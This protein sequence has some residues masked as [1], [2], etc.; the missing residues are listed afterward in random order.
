[1]RLGDFQQ[2]GTDDRPRLIM[3][4]EDAAG[5]S[6]YELIVTGSREALRVAMADAELD[7]HIDSSASRDR[8]EAEVRAMEEENE[9]AAWTLSGL[10]ELDDMFKDAPERVDARRSV[11]TSLRRTRG[12]GTYYEAT[13]AN[14][15]PWPTGVNLIA[16]MPPSL[17]VGALV[18][19]STGDQDLYHYL[20][21]HLQPVQA[22]VRPG[23]LIDTLSLVTAGSI[24]PYMFWRVHWFTG[25]TCGLF[26]FAGYAGRIGF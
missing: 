1:M 21:S 12:E 7:V 2:T 23:T 22:S 20:G 13:Y 14:L 17:V 10:D 11:L 18:A 5:L 9:R 3:E 16:F 24:Y 25:G 19:P 6:A 4:I 26:R 15:G 8:A